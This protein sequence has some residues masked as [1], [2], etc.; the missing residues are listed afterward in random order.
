MP[1]EF[2][3]NKDNLEV[4][5]RKLGKKSNYIPI[6]NES[7]VEVAKTSEEMSE[8]YCIND[9][10]IKEIGRVGILLEEHFGF[11]QDV[12]WATDQTLKLPDSIVLLQTRNEVIAQ[13]KSAVDTVLDMMIGGFGV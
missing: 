5:N 10:E 4:I 12:E 7:G 6:R 8:T 1:D 11:P 9:D 13:K 2:I 3:V